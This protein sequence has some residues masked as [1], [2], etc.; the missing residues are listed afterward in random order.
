[1]DKSGS[2]WNVVQINCLRLAAM[3][4]ILEQIGL[5]EHH[6]T[7]AAVGS[8]PAKILVSGRQKTGLL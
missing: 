3:L 6:I 8:T 5:V 1:M 7:S 4:P 2:E